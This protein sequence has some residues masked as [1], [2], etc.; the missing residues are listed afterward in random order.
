[1]D[2]WKLATLMYGVTSYAIFFLTFLYAIAFVS[3]L[4]VAKTIDTGDVGP[5]GRA[6]L[7]DIFLLSLF[8]IQH[9]VMA[10]RSFKQWW[11]R[12]VPPPIERSTYVLFSSLALILLFWQW[13]PIPGAVWNLDNT[14]A[15][16]AAI[17][18][19]F[20]GW[21]I[22]LLS[23]F[24]LG[25]LEL[26][27]LHQVASELK[28]KAMPAPQFRTPLFYKFV[29][30]PLYFGFIVAFWATPTMTMGHLLFAIACTVYIL[31]GVFFEERDLVAL[32]GDDY[33][34]YQD[35][36]SMLLPWRKSP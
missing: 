18:L 8:A 19:S 7:V 21:G 11:T 10:R 20:I 23:T 25:H 4:V 6:L 28:A 3:N 15:A 33:R 24:L 29:R 26:F 30:H 13:R 31:V 2:R 12:Y 1:M 32:F 17:V 27:G 5:P 14:Y 16:N 34:H 9:S 36:V 35:R 22:V